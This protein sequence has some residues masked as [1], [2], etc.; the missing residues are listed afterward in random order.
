[1]EIIGEE[2]G[3]SSNILRATFDGLLFAAGDGIGYTL[4]SPLWLLSL[5]RLGAQKGRPAGFDAG[6]RFDPTGSF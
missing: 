5:P 2:R 6:D 3:D 4:G 1:V